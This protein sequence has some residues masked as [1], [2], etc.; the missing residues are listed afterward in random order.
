MTAEV[1]A[2]IR[3]GIFGGRFCDLVFK[4]KEDEELTKVIHLYESKNNRFSIT[5]FKSE[6]NINSLRYVDEFDNFVM[7][8][9]RAFC[10]IT[11]LI[12]MYD[13]DVEVESEPEVFWN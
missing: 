7:R 4:C 13:D 5:R 2:D 12:D 11:D 6:L 1:T 9:D 10:D 8:L 3:D